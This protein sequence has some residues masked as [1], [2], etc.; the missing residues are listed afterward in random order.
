MASV[1]DWISRVQPGAQSAPRE[2][3]LRAIRDAVREFC[4]RTRY[5][6]HQTTVTPVNG[7]RA[8]AISV[9]DETE[10][11][12]LIRVKQGNRT[13]VE[14]YAEEELEAA[15]GT[16]PTTAGSVISG[17]Y[18]TDRDQLGLYPAPNVDDADD[19][20]VLVSVRPTLTGTV[21]SDD[22]HQDFVQEIA[23]GAQAEL[24]MMPGTA[25]YDPALAQYHKGVFDAAI[26]KGKV[27]ADRQHTR[28]ARRR[29]RAQWF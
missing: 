1:S 5:W 4:T 23:C 26:R 17:A 27:Q 13:P 24:L 2:L 28:K 21:V 7:A 20:R 9:P 11:V 3:V 22:L 15:D 14:L 12:D 19:V 10:L 18:L 25:W 16:F 29:V 6:Q 8:Y